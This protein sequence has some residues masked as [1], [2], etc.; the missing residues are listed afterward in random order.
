MKIF[1]K[2]LLF[3]LVAFIVMQFFRPEKNLSGQT[4][5]NDIMT[6]YPIPGDVK[7]IL[8]KACNDCHSNNTTYPWYSN[9][10]PVAWWLDDHIK[11]GKK[12]LNISEF[13]SY[14]LRRQYHKMEE[15]EEMVEKKEMPLE[16]YT[17]I[18]K[19]ANL[20]EDERNKIIAWSV[21]IRDTMKAKYPMD[22]LVAKKK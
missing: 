12:H 2:V 5:R 8:V 20:T 1:R 4:S 22:S 18:H 19:D 3:L 11:E 16:S 21:S 7:S 13:A 14:S 6:L 9:I 15:V 10:Q 17:Y